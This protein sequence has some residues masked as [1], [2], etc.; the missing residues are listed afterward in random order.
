VKT[1]YRV[2]LLC[3]ALALFLTIVFRALETPF[4]NMNG[5]RLMPSFAIARG[6]NYYV[7]V[8]PGGP[9]YSSLY[10]PMMSIVYLPA[11][12]FP[13]P[14]SAVLA[15]A[16]TTILLCFSAAAYLHFAPREGGL[17]AVDALAFLT[18]GF[19]MCYLSP[20]KYSCINIHADG[21]GLAFAAVACGA[22]Y[23]DGRASWR[24]ALPISA[25]CAVF[26]VLCKQMFLPVPAALLA[27][28]LAAEGRQ[29]TLQYMAWLAAAGGSSAAAV[30]YAYGPEQIYHCLIWIP[31]HQPWNSAS[32][33]LS[34]IQAAREFLRLSAPVTVLLLASGIYFCASRASWS[35]TKLRALAARRCAP[36]LFVGF[37]LLPFSIAGRAKIGGDINSLS[38]ALFFFTCGLTVMLADVARRAEN[39]AIRRLA[40]AVLAG[41]IIPLAISETPLAAEIPS[42]IRE[43]PHSDQATALAYLERHPGGAYFPWFPIS[44]FYA[45]RQ[46]RHFAFGVLDRVAAGETITDEQFRAYIPKDPQV[47][48]FGKDGTRDMFGFN[49]MRFLPEYTTQTA[50]AEL[51]GWVTYTKAAGQ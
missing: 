5:A 32:R 46:F 45:E 21:P 42:L 30:L 4:W 47:I 14:N 2:G 6:I 44:H 36:L 41:V 50:N 28:L 27:Y 37:A 8:P 18:A 15:G 49:L 26:S 40:I 35:N 19:L 16:A 39:A 1:L 31:G 38:F 20:L 13:S 12:L 34:S 43:L 25:V 10:G 23:A 22:L 24:I 3:A 51:P 33:M 7:L 29:R 17:G 11:T 9:L 48:A